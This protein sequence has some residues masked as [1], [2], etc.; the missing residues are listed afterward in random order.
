MIKL[1][2]DRDSKTARGSNNS[3]QIV[4]IDQNEKVFVKQYESRDR[5]NREIFY[6]KW[7]RDNGEVAIPDLLSI[8][9]Q[10]LTITQSY[11][12]P[13]DAHGDWSVTKVENC[14]S[15][16]RRIINYDSSVDFP[17]AKGGISSL[18]GHLVDV[19]RRYDVLKDYPL[20]DQSM[21]DILDRIIDEYLETKAQFETFCRTNNFSLFDPI[22]IF[23]SPSDFGGDN[24]IWSKE[25]PIFVDFEYSGVD[26]LTKA[27]CDFFFRPKGPRNFASDPSLYSG[28]GQVNSER[29]CILVLELKRVTSLRWALILLGQIRKASRSSADVLCG[30]QKYLRE[31]CGWVN[32]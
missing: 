28:F 8:D 14:L 27:L 26:D 32:I 24:V 10:S 11:V 2:K 29:L 16:L 5:F 4:N 17:S 25:G 1:P 3:V 21:N 30:V 7:L 31:D 9:D 19:E 18:R 15:F 22:C 20:L 13:F 6:L 12:R 23:V